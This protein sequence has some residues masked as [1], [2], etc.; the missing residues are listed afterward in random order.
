[1]DFHANITRG[2][3]RH[4]SAGE[5]LFAAMGLALLLGDLLGNLGPLAGSIVLVGFSLW[6]VACEF[7]V[8]TAAARVPVSILRCLAALGLLIG[9]LLLGPVALTGG[10]LNAMQVILFSGVAVT[11][12]ASMAAGKMMGLGI[13]AECDVRPPHRAWRVLCLAAGTAALVVLFVL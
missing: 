10:V 5:T 6:H 8:V 4:A 11:C 12:A 2:P 3:L 13:L 9:F 1:M 7:Y